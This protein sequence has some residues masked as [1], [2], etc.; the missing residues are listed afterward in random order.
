MREKT[1]NVSEINC[2]WDLVVKLVFTKHATSLVKRG[3]YLNQRRI[4]SNLKRLIL[5]TSN[6]CQEVFAHF[7]WSTKLSRK[8]P[9]KAMLVLKRFHLESRGKGVAERVK[10]MGIFGALYV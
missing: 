9:E 5:P 1:L 4:K 6:S 2:A 3:A 8:G 10:P 7:L